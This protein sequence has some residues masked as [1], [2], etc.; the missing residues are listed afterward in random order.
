MLTYKNNSDTVVIVLHEI[1]GINDHIMNICNQLSKRK[2][3]IIVPNL[4]QDRIKFSYDQEE[5]AYNYFV[6]NIGFESA[7]KQI[8]QILY[9]VRLQYA[10]IYVLGY[11]I[12]ATLAWLC[13]QTKLCDLVVGFYGS[14]IRDYLTVIPQCPA[15]LLFPTEEKAFAVDDLIK[16]LSEIKGV[17]IKKING[18]H[19]FADPFSKKYNNKSAFIATKEVL[20]FVK[21]S[22]TK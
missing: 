12:G 13:S 11:S 14:R 5:A 4:L 3:D 16:K 1:Y 6:E 21:G 8:K 15:L 18:K 7:M 10:K 17:I 9:D 20:F 19:G 22:L 2:Y